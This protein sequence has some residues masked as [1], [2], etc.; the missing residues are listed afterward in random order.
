MSSLTK[1]E[2]KYASAMKKNL[3]I[4]F[5]DYVRTNS[6][7]FASEAAE[8]KNSALTEMATKLSNYGNL[9]E[10]LGGGISDGY[11]GYLKGRIKSNVEGTLEDADKAVREKRHALKRGYLDYLTSYDKGQKSL[12]RSVA[13]SLTDNRILDAEQMYQ[14]ATE[15]GLSP[16][17]V[18]GLYNE[19]YRI[20]SHNVKNEILS[21]VHINEIVPSVAATLAKNAGLNAA[22]V[23]EIKEAAKAYEKEFSGY[24][25]GYLEY[26][27]QLANQNTV[28]FK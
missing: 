21:K 27:E 4:S 5:A 13:K 16:S 7:D 6:G 11:S 14:Y 19:V 2:Q 8:K 12:R 25:E 23:E 10:A 3:P 18:K 15:A 17:S 9:G 24:S 28:T 26:L 22:D 1:L 20:V